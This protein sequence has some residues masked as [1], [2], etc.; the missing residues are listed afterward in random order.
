MREGLVY[1]FA[2]YDQYHRKL[3]GGV[4]QDSLREKCFGEC[5]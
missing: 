3:R 4:I 1:T 2:V 5:T